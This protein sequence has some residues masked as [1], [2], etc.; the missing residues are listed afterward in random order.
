MPAELEVAQEARPR[1]KFW[2]NIVVFLAVVGPGL[3]TANVD[4]D[5]GGI[6]TYSLAGAQYGNKLLWTLI[7]ITIALIVVQEMCARMGVMTGKG[8]ADLIRE[9]Y[10]VKVTFWIMMALL[11]ANAG[12]TVAEFSGVAASMQIFGVP[13][14]ISVPITALAV[15]LLVLK[16]TYQMVEKVFLVACVFYVAYPVSALLSHPDWGTVMR[17]TVTPSFEWK[18]DYVAMLIGVVGTTIAPW[19]QFYLQ[20]AVVEKGVKP[21]QYR[22]SRLDVIVG[23]IITDVVAFFIIVACS[24]TLFKAGVKVETADQAAMALAPLAGKYASW[25]FAA[26]LFNASFFAASI[27]PLSTAYFMCEA[28]GWESGV[29]KKW[30]QARQ[31]YV[32]YTGIIVLGAGVVLLPHL[33]LLK[34]ML[35]SQI[36]NGVLLPFILVF[37]LL[38]INKEKLMGKHRNGRWF[39]GISWGTTAIMI[40]LTLY[41][42]VAGVRDLVRG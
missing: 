27:L 3:I 23:C 29:D 42:V 11:L 2:R 9:N 33:P 37:M 39:N 15:W 41:L 30:S 25:L 34:I 35:V 14:W 21:E 5:A 18:G 10:G 31:F 16:G 12:N 20:S 38:L 22:L 4:N 40:V 28:F 13:A 17:E 7:P 1:R 19:M 36:A 8:L 24:T 6:T 26:G 32:L